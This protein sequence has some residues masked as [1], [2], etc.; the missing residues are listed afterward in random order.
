VNHLSRLRESWIRS[1]SSASFVNRSPSLA[2]VRALAVEPNPQTRDKQ[3]RNRI[4]EPFPL[5]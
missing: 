4:A 3:I 5:G 2:D 1:L